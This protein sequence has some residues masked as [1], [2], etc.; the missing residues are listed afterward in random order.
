[1]GAGPGQ[2]LSCP[3]S[4]RSGSRDLLREVRKS[5]GRQ[6]LA[7]APGGGKDTDS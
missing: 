1:M 7:V 5:Q 3:H 4:A 6:R 2:S